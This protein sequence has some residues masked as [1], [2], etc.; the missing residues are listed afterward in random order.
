[1]PLLHSSNC[2]TE[3]KKTKRE[4]REVAIIAVL[5]DGGMAVEP[6]PTTTKKHG[7]LYLFHVVILEA[8]SGK[9]FASSAMVSDAC[10]EFSFC[11]VNQ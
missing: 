1:M 6:V 10:S 5:A 7:L 11:T 2:H 4:A 3:R 9:P 8:I